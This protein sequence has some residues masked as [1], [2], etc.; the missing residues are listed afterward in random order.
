MGLKKEP[1][2]NFEFNPAN[3][4][5]LRIGIVV[6]EWSQTITGSLLDACWETLKKYKIRE[7]NILVKWVPGSFELALGGQ[8]LVEYENVDAVICLGCIIKGETPH[9]HYISTTVSEN[10]GKL[11]IKFGRPFIF[12]V[13]TTENEEHALARAGGKVGNKGEE[14]AMAALKM[15]QLKSDLKKSGKNIGFI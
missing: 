4:D 2:G 11:S 5:R 10:I 9:F 15:L 6:S 12:G 3:I 13:L 14:A 8:W 1:Q 7:E